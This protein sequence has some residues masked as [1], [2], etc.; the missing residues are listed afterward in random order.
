MTNQYRNNNGKRIPS[1]TTI[2]KVLSINGNDG[3][4][5]WANQMGL[6]GKTLDDARKTSS[7]VG[8]LAHLAVEAKIK[9]EDIDYDK[10]KMTT[11]QRSLVT[12][13]IDEWDRWKTQTK[14]E[15]VGTEIKLVSE[16]M[17]Y[18]GTLDCIGY[19]DNRLCLLDLKTGNIYPEHLAQI[20][21]YGELWRENKNQIIDEYH[22]L[23]IGKHDASWHHHSWRADSHIIT[24]AWQIFE[25]A[26]KI[27]PIAGQLKK[28]MS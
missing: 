19:V 7:D 15:M 6:E 20:R 9:N 2:L 13:C 12:T 5:F 16:E 18:G 26:L 1:V 14:L 28:A 23:R 11:E 21:A 27:Y 24:T 25:L 3:L 10:W 4:L 22:L 17:Q 8:T